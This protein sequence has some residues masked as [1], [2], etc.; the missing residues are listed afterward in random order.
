[1][2]AVLVV[3]LVIVAHGQHSS[4]APKS[5]ARAKTG[6]R[7][8]S[9]SP[10]A[11]DFGRVEQQLDSIDQTLRKSDVDLRLDA[12]D[13]SI[14]ELKRSSILST[15]LP[16]LIAFL[17]AIVGVLIGGWVNYELQRRRLV[18]EEKI[19]S[20]RAEH[21]KLLA[22][23]KASQER[24]LSERQSKLQ[25]GSAVVEWQLK[26]LY[27]LYGP[28]RALLGQSFGLYRQMNKVLEKAD[29]ER[30]RFVTVQDP[31]GQNSEDGEQFQIRMPSQEWERFRM[32]MH[33]D[34]VYGRGFG[35]ETYFYEIVSIGARVVTIIE[36]NAGYARP[37]EAQLMN[38]FAQYLA[39]FAVLKHLHGMARAVLVKA[40]SQSNSS[41]T[42]TDTIEN[43]EVDVSAVFPVELHTLINQGFNA[44]TKDIEQWR[45]KALA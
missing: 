17:A 30:F 26:Q 2:A 15:L 38:V 1:M 8:K 21:E 14:V 43:L 28:V 4:L 33:I 31:Q 6:Q 36:Q 25:I 44:I 42:E 41:T 40:R 45:G 13:K 35:V 29:R 34:Q 3:P 23:A 24:E 10:S 18:Q 27:L 7:Q 32:V 19:A 20:D 9:Q 37:E 39:H 16:A 11:E 12:I 22:D 5:S